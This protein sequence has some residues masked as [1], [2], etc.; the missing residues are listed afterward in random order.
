MVDVEHV[1]E[2][3]DAV[4]DKGRDYPLGAVQLLARYALAA[5]RGHPLDRGEEDEGDQDIVEPLL[6]EKGGER[7]IECP[8]C[9]HE[10]KQ[11][12]GLIDRDVACD[13]GE[14]RGE[15]EGGVGG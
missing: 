3:D 14:G 13:A 12:K 2:G 6:V 10:R 15:E 4:D 1:D 5:V 9:A 7:N 8:D 11:D